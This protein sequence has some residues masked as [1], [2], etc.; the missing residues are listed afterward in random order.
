M[1]TTTLSN[2]RTRRQCSAVHV[3]PFFVLRLLLPHLYPSSSSTSRQQ[4]VGLLFTALLYSAAAASYSSIGLLFI[5][6]TSLVM[7]RIIYSLSATALHCTASLY[8]F[9]FLAFSFPYFSL[10]T[11][12]QW[13]SLRLIRHQQQQS[14]AVFHS[15][16]FHSSFVSF[17]SKLYL[18]TMQK[19]ETKQLPGRRRRKMTQQQFMFATT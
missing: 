10:Y 19:R 6:T 2:G 5:S 8:P 14:S 11:S 16:P 9:F 13:H 17:F 3:F 7:S 15:V 1:T 18:M 4:R 12:Q